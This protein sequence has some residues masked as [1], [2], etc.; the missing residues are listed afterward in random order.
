MKHQKKYNI[1]CIGQL[2]QDILVVNIPEDA[3]TRYSTLADELILS[4]GGDAANECC[5]IARLGSEVTLYAKVEKGPAGDSL[6]SNM[7]SEGINPRFILQADD[8]TTPTAIVVIKPDGEHS[9]I[10][11]EGKNY[12]LLPED[13]DLDVIRSARAIT[14]G[15]L[16]SLGNLD[17]GGI[18]TIFQEAQKADVLTFADMDHDN[19][20]LG[21]KIFEDLYPHIDYLIPSVDEAVYV[22]GISESPKKMAEYFLDRGVKNVLIKL[23]AKGSYFRNR[24]KSF[25][26][27]PYEVT[28]KD[29][30]GCGDCFTGGFVHRIMSGDSLEDA[31]LFATACGGMNSLGYGGHLYIQ[32]EAHVREFM[33][34]TPRRSVEY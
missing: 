28:P 21:N 32:S 7:R 15:S 24:E 22:T 19:Y 9:F 11:K 1:I 26:T 8:C 33:A 3:L 5:T 23:G 18:I 14:A 13:V 2:I 12:G 17:K 25:Y 27:E 6:I 30:T 16:Y 20:S 4:S 29:T 31:V 34:S 10:I